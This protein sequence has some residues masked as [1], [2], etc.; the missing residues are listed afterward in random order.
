MLSVEAGIVKRV[1]LL[2][3]DELEKCESRLEKHG[4]SCLSVDGDSI[5]GQGIYCSTSAKKPAVIA[6]SASSVLT[7]TDS[8]NEKKNE[9]QTIKTNP[10]NP[11][12]PT[13]SLL[14]PATENTPP[15]PFP[16]LTAE[17]KWLFE[18]T[19]SLQQQIQDELAIAIS[20]TSATTTT[21]S[22][23]VV[24]KSDYTLDADVVNKKISPIEEKKRIRNAF[25][26]QVEN[27][28][29]QCA[30]MADPEARSNPN[31]DAGRISGGKRKVDMLKQLLKKEDQI[32]FPD[33]IA[34][35]DG[36]ID[37]EHREQ[38]ELCFWECCGTT[39]VPS[40]W[41]DDEGRWFDGCWVVW[42]LGNSVWVQ[43][44]VEFMFYE[45]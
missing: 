40:F 38:R 15:T 2:E 18:K 25:L 13:K 42:V 30:L 35:E 11:T 39:W 23:E 27:A 20:A 17:E 7:N 21:R 6:T 36:D 37:Q 19:Q 4:S 44:S 12:N 1:D 45:Q 9:E 8:N 41:V 22:T 33:Y 16:N 28:Y 34:I 29:R 32:V 26:F 43:G 31:P 14:F 24:N 3:L 5:A 10:I